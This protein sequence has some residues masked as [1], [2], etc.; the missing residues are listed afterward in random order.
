MDSVYIKLPQ[1]LRY[2]RAILG[3]PECELQML[4]T[5]IVLN[6]LGATLQK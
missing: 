6:F 2:L 5:Q 1:I 3:E 4:D